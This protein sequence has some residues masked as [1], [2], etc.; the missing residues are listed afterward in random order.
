MRVGLYLKKIFYEAEGSESLLKPILRKF[1]KAKECVP[2]STPKLI[3]FFK[4]W[5]GA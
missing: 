2:M 1:L 5:R 3:N 4:G